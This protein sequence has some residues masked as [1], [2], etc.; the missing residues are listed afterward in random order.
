MQQTKHQQSCQYPP[1]S[2]EENKFQWPKNKPIAH[3]AG[4]QSEETRVPSSNLKY[5]PKTMRLP[6]VS[7]LNNNLTGGYGEDYDDQID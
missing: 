3:L 7:I 5:D 1:N 4:R 2:L 6:E